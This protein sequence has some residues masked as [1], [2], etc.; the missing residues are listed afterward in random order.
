MDN[1]TILQ[2]IKASWVELLWWLKPSI[3]FYILQMGLLLAL[4]TAMAFVAW[5]KL[6]PFR[7]TLSQLLVALCCLAIVLQ[8]PLEQM[9]AHDAK[10]LYA[11]QVTMALLF[12]LFLPYLF[13]FFITP[14][15]RHQIFV[16]KVITRAIWILLVAQLFL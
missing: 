9:R 11:F 2:G 5:M 4:T 12:M 1:Q 10:G 14:I 7:S 6:G 16:V 13:A 3:T 8:I 15:R